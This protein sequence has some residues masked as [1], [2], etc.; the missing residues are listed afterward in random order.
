MLVRRG[1]IVPV[2][3]VAQILIGPNPPV[4]KFYLIA[5]RELGGASEWTAIPVSGECELASAQ[6]VAPNSKLPGYVSGLLAF[7]SEIVEVVSLE[8][9][10]AQEMNP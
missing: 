3:D 5:N 10:M 4:R 6:P 8:K 1:H 7:G 2:Y 9:L